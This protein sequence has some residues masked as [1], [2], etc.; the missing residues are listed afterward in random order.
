[1]VPQILG[2]PT[3]GTFA[4]MVVIPADN[5][6]RKPTYLTWEE[7]GVLSLSALTAYRALF[8]RAHIKPGEHVLIPGIGG[9]VATYAMLMAQ[10]AGLSSASLP[11]AKP[12]SK[13][14]G[15]ILCIGLFEQRGLERR[16]ARGEGGRD[17]G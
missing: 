14:R 10:T 12:S 13:K 5:V 17:S 7:A 3:D 16:A 1:M 11:E 6:F 4:E 9:G 15:A 8:T 2:G